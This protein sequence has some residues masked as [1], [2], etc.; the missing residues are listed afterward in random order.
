MFR[1]SG[2]LK[3]LQLTELNFSH[4]SDLLGAKEG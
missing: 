2:A 4:V 1:F 3:F